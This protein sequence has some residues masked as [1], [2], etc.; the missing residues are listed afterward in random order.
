MMNSSIMAKCIVVFMDDRK[1]TDELDFSTLTGRGV[2]IAIIDSGVDSEH[3]EIGPITHGMDIGIGSDGQIVWG[4]D[5][6]DRLGHGTA[7]S[8]IIRQIAPKAEIYI[9]RIFERS[10]VADGR[11]LIAAL[12]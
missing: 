2:K 7:C 5:Y 12:Q 8:G 6:A 10:L 11:V 4:T 9:L 1:N 3:P